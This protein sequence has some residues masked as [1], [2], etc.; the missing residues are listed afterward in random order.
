M[1]RKPVPL[2]ELPALAERW[3]GSLGLSVEVRPEPSG[4]EELFPNRVVLTG[5]DAALFMADRGQP[6]DAFQYLLHEAQML[7]DDARLVYLDVRG[8][9]RFRMTELK[10]MTELA[11]AKARAT[12]SYT[13]G[14]LS[15]RERR[16]IHVLVGR[17]EGLATE[18]EGTGNFK[19]LKIFKA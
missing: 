6:L 4:D 2:E 11:I 8:M 16:W 1:R 3:C 17:E 10:A 7:K 19:P 5:T 14:P 15:P 9:R 18:S 13:F 12:G